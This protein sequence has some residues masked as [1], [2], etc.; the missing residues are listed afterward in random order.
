MPL[1]GTGIQNP[2][3]IVDFV[4]VPTVDRGFWPLDFCEMEIDGLKP[5]MRSTSGLGICPRNC[6]AKLDRLST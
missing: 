5:E 4:I 6:R 2:Q 1:A 3:I